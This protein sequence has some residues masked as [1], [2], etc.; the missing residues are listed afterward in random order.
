M[1]ITC[2]NE[3]EL[4]CIVVF[5]ITVTCIW[6]PICHVDNSATIEN[7][8][9]F[10]VVACEFFQLNKAPLAIASV[11]VVSEKVPVVDAVMFTVTFPSEAAILDVTVPVAVFA[12]ALVVK[13]RFLN[14]H[15]NGIGTCLSDSESPLS[16]CANGI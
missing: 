15:L 7:L 5:Y 11:F 8:V 12:F 6:L 4:W 10:P 16:A 3:F 14:V 9:V 13:Y 2:F 1:Y